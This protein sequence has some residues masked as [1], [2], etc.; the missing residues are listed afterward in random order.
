MAFDEVRF[1]TDI[2][3][4]SRGGPR[5][6]TAIA[7]L[8]SGAEER[9]ARFSYPLHTYE[10]NYGIKSYAQLV[11]VRDFFIARLGAANGF[12][13]KDFYD[14]STDPNA[15]SAVS[16]P[17]FTNVIIGTGDGTT[18][19]FQLVKKYTSGAV[20][21]TR[22][23]TKPVSGTVKSGFGGVEKTE[24][25]HWTVNTTTG[26]ITYTT[27]PTSGQS[28]TAGCDFDVPVRFGDDIDEAGLEIEAD[29]FNGGSIP[30]IPLIEYFESAPSASDEFYYGGSSSFSFG[31]NITI[32][33]A[34]GRVIILSPTGAGLKAALP[35]T[36]NIPDGGEHWFLVNTSG[37]NTVIIT[38]NA[39]VT[40]F[41][42]AT[43]GRA[44]VVLGTVGGVKTWYGFA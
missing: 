13:Y 25:T 14:Y 31:A 1:P 6:S 42:L 19:T 33:P 12:R 2:S 32:T 21:R 27:A 37:T 29:F 10:V 41:T 20:T 16:A 38:D 44:T 39:G 17:V 23:V 22:N 28:V 43:S 36:T 30:T 4:G 18:T 24:G 5:F 11:T 8:R 15:T 9:V 35:A 34:N 7:K 26:I 3:Y 40:V